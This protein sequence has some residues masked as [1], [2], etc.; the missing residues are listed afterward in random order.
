MNKTCKPLNSLELTQLGTDDSAPDQ[1]LA[2]GLHLLCFKPS[3]EELVNIVLKRTIT[4]EICHVIRLSRGTLMRQ[5]LSMINNGLI[6]ICAHHTQTG[7]FVLGG[8]L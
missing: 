3:A 5:Y 1:E 8:T 7:V 4:F 6:E 2:S